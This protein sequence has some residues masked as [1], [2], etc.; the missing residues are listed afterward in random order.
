M[1]QKEI[2]Q[3]GLGNVNV[4]QFDA[5]SGGEI[6]DLGDQR[7]AT[8]GV[9]VRAIAVGGAHFPD[10]SQ[11]LE[12]LHELRGVPA[13]AEA[14]E[15]AAG[16]GSLLLLW[17]S[18]GDDAAVINDGRRTVQAARHPWSATRQPLSASERY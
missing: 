17:S 16:N 7:T 15:E 11:A 9:Q 6:G 13:E 4:T 18:Q 8:V 3:T 12:T 1:V 5:S 2:F 14:Q 10:A